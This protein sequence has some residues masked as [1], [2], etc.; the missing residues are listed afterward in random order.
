MTQHRPLELIAADQRAAA[1]AGDA[2]ALRRFGDELLAAKG[3]TAAELAA[4]DRRIA[5][6]EH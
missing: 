3:I 1:I 6:A 2:D 5:G 4:E